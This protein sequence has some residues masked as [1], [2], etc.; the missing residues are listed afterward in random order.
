M[1]RLRQ[2]LVVSI[3]ALLASGLAVASEIYKWTDD[4]GNVHYVDR[5][6]GQPDETRLDIYSARTD[7]SAVQARVQQ[8]RQSRAAADQVASE[9]PDEMRKEELRA[10]QQERQEQCQKYRARLE[11]YLQSQRLYKEDQSG[12]RVYLDEDETLAART[13][14]EEQIKEYCGS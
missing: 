6:T 3:T 8:R 10:A 9:A 14:V 12:E 7:N 4:E 2:L 13:R 5:P 11:K 1:T